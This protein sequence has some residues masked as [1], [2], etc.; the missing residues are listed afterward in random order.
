[1]RINSLWLFLPQAVLVILYFFLL[2]RAFVRLRLS[3]K[4]ALFF[5][6]IILGSTFLP[7]IPLLRGLALNVGGM[8]LPLGIALYLIVTAERGA[9]KKRA[10]LTAG[11]VAAAVWLL[12][13]LLPRDPGY[14]GFDLDPLFMPS[15]AAAA[16]A[17]LLGRS[18]R[19]AFSGAVLGVFFLEMASW[20]EN[21]LKGFPQ[22]R[23][24]LG[25]GGIFGP[26]VVS[27]ALAL[28]LAEAAG[29]IRERLERGGKRV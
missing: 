12:N 18:R 26:A 15:L 29:E 17:Y 2:Y 11:A 6:F 5:L 22:A 24:I 10:L 25:G 13:R 3:P 4:T 23:V 9:E 7:D 14:L 28:F 21:L 8:G 27:G 20:M 19:A 16:L 1:M